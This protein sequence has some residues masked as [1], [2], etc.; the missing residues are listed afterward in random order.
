MKVLELRPPDPTASKLQD[1]AEGLSVSPEQMSI[2]RIEENLAQ[3]KEEF[4]QSAEYV[5]KKNDEL[6]RRLS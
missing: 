6:Y 5:L 1:A 2:L 3:L 4:G